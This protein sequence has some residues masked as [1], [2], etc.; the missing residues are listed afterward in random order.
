[1]QANKFVVPPHCGRPD[2]I[3]I[4]IHFFTKNNL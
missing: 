4:T 2:I 1:M 3:L